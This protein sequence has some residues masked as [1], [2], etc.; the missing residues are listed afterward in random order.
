MNNS[1]NKIFK[2]NTITIAHIVNNAFNSFFRQKKPKTIETFDK[3][4]IFKNLVEVITQNVILY[5]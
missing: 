3:S 5:V 4:G 1:I 2:R